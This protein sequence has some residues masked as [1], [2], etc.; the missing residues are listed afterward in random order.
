MKRGILCKQKKK[1]AAFLLILA[2]TGLAETVCSVPVFSSGEETACSEAEPQELFRSPDGTESR[3]EEQNGTQNQ[4]K[5]VF[6]KMKRK[7][8][9]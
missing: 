1:I 3:K 2:M 4:K 8:Q 6:R 5:S 9:E 7:G